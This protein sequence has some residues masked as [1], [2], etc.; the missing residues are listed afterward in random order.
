LCD[1]SQEIVVKEHDCG[2]S[3][4]LIISKAEI[5]SYNGDFEEALYGRVAAADV[6]DNH[7]T[8][9]LHKD[10]LIT[11]AKLQLIIESE[12]EFVDVRSSMLCKTISGVCQKCYGMDLATREIVRLGTPVGIIAAQSI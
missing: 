10:D 9:I 4:S 1:S 5:E 2:T 8:I 3:A 12:V 11:K 7:G 6:L